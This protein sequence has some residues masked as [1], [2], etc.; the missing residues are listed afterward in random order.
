M[1]ERT[2]KE[3]LWDALELVE[4]EFMSAGM[5]TVEMEE[6]VARWLA[7]LQEATRETD[8]NSDSRSERCR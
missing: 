8:A 4:D 3:K 2:L 7:S 1:T 5:H 6:V